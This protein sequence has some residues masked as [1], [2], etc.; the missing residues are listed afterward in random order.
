MAKKLHPP[1]TSDRVK[2][3][4]G[5]GLEA[6]SRLS[7]KQVRELAGSVLRHIAPRKYAKITKPK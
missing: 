7:T 2:H 1:I 3:L 5:E 6:P 4:A